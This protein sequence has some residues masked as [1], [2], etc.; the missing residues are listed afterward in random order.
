MGNGHTVWE[1][2]SRPSPSQPRRPDRLTKILPEQ[3]GR[4]QPRD[5][6]RILVEAEAFPYPR[7]RLQ[8]VEQ[9]DLATATPIPLVDR[10]TWAIPID[11]ALWTINNSA[12]T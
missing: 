9:P 2:V 10:I 11:V 1:N 3:L 8:N 6:L 7:S 4:Y 5:P 12:G